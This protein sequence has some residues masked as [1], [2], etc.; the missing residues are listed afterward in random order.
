MTM[1]SANPSRCPSHVDKLEIYSG[2]TWNL[3]WCWLILV[4]YGDEEQGSRR[5]GK[6]A[7]FCETGGKSA[8]AP[9]RFRRHRLWGMC[10]FNYLIAARFLFYVYLTAEIFLWHAVGF[11][12][13]FVGYVFWMDFEQ[14]D[15]KQM[16]GCRHKVKGF[17]FW[18]WQFDFN[19]IFLFI[20][21]W[22][23]ESNSSMED[24]ELGTFS[25]PIIVLVG[26]LS[27]FSKNLVLVYFKSN[28]LIV[29]I[30]SKFY[31]SFVDL[32]IF[33]DWFS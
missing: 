4:C 31:S 1:L 7:C 23:F 33:S 14:S 3:R 28:I 8:V 12:L 6:E 2:K 27:K 32:S 11:Y 16:G 5:R 30:L 19:Q 26:D 24:D 10:C 17:W 13:F 29:L 25:W 18:V 20:L 22:Y 9:F 21:S 15:I